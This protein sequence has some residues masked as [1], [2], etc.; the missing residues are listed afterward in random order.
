MTY[1]LLKVVHF[2]VATLTLTLWWGFCIIYLKQEFSFRRPQELLIT[3]FLHAFVSMFNCGGVRGSPE[4]AKWNLG[5]INTL[6]REVFY[7]WPSCVRWSCCYWK[8]SS[9][10]SKVGKMGLQGFSR[11]SL[12]VVRVHFNGMQQWRQ[13]KWQIPCIN[14]NLFVFSLSLIH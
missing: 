7:R 5:I 6:A 11:L 2:S 1:E 4:M 8:H 14:L 13:S 3:I 10:F 9:E 12:H